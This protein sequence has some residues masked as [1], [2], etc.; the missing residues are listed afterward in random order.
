MLAILLFTVAWL[1]DRHSLG[2]LVRHSE[3]WLD[4]RVA[5]WVVPLAAAA[6]FVVGIAYGSTAAIASDQFGYV[7]QSVLWR[8]GELR[9]QMPVAERMPWPDATATL[10][11]LG[12][13]PSD[14]TTIVPV[15]PPGFPLL[16]AVARSLS[17]CAPFVVVPLC[18][19]IL[20]LVTWRLGTRLFG[21]EVGIVGA[22]MTVASP[23]VLTW[24]LSPMSDVPATT[25]WLGSLL[26][27][28]RRTKA[29]A[30][31]T[32]I[33]TGCAIAI[34]PNLAPLAIFPLLLV[35]IRRARREALSH[36]VRVLAGLLPVVIALL[37]FNATLYGSAWTTG[38]GDMSQRFSWSHLAP[39]AARYPAWWWTAHGVIGWLFLVHL[40]WRF[41]TE[42]RWRVWT[43]IGFV[44]GIAASY[45]LYVP[46]DHWSYLR[47]ALPA[48]PILMLLSAYA[49]SRVLSPF[50][51]DVRRFGLAA[52]AV[53]A[54]LHG[55]HL[56]RWSGAFTQ[57][58]LSQ[59]FVD[60]G[61]YVDRTTGPSA[62]IVSS[63]H[64]GSVAYYSG[65]LILRYELL[66]P[67]W[68]DRAL[69]NLRQLGFEPYALLEDAEV[70]AWRERFSSAQSTRALD[71]PAIAFLPQ[72][73]GT[74]RLFRLGPTDDV[75]RNPVEIPRSSKFDC[76]QPSPRFGAPVALPNRLAS[77]HSSETRLPCPG[78][79]GSLNCP[80]HRPGDRPRVACSTDRLARLAAAVRWRRL[81][82]PHD[83]EK[84]SLNPGGRER[85][86]AI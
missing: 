78:D 38:Y 62:V 74:L 79:R 35:T 57:A 53:L 39:N 81:A 83:V 73:G 21:H 67:A 8:R 55:V 65:R 9:I 36:G 23:V 28:D 31:V 20:T 29:S 12:Y 34:R 22:I 46:F 19:A 6:V 66:D 25:F 76:V 69:D 84:D 43:L 51:R 75:R 37:W 68:L 59:R 7:S 80:R 13:R 56:A 17:A 30:V 1:L 49:A 44:A 16:M 41:P 45:A 18:A 40:V 26:A 60:A 27:A 63:L 85:V 82:T 24:T 72:Q 61:L 10:A 2:A 33:L 11:P 50:G 47:F 70:R 77:G 5:R 86:S 3:R 71:N 64:S 4:D 42:I 52:T 14:A 54:L 58:A 48:L 32:G 15:Y